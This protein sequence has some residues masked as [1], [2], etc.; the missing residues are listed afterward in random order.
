MDLRP[1]QKQALHWLSNKE[2]NLSDRKDVSLHPLWE[3]YLWP[4][5]DQDDQELPQVEGLDKFY[6]NPYLGE[7][8]IE[9]PRQEQNCLGG[10]LADEMGLGKT[11]LYPYPPDTAIANPAQLKCLAWCTQTPTLVVVSHGDL[12]RGSWRAWAQHLSLRR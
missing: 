5:K 7:L 11:S 2:K 1:Y 6:V 8:S 10:I 4:T 3:E 9:F 12:Q